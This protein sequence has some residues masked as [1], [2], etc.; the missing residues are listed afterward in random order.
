MSRGAVA[1]AAR[2]GLARK[3]VQTIVLALVV[4]VSTGASVL[5]LALVVDSSAPF[6]H[7]F[8]AQKG[9]DVSATADPSRVTAAQL[10]A[11]GR[12]PD[13][14][15]AAGPFGAVTIT[16]KLSSLACG[17]HAPAAGG[18]GGGAPRPPGSGPCGASLVFPPVTLVGRGSPGGSVDDVALQSGHWV[19]GPGQIVL[20]AGQNNFFTPSLG[21]KIIASDAPGKP[22]L[23]VVGYAS[24]ITDTAG[25]WVAP[26]E[27]S[28]LTSAQTPVS[29]QMLYRFRNAGTEQALRADMRAVAAALPAGA[30]SGTES[31]LAV[32][33]QETGNIAPFVPFL[34][35][36]GVIGMVMSVLIVVNVVSGAVVAGYRRIGILKSLGFTPGQ[37]VAAYTGQIAVPAVV[38]ALIGLVLGNV[39]AV[40]VLK[41]TASAYQIGSLRVPLWVDVAVPVAM[42]VLVAVA[43]MLSA[44]RAGRLS[45]VQA[46]AIG[47]APRTGR[48]YT[49]HRLLGRLNLPRPVTIG[50]AAPFSRPAR[51]V[52]TLSAVLLGAIAVTFAVGLSSS[53]D[54]VVSGLSHTTSEP[55][56]VAL[57]GGQGP[58]GGGAVISQINGG[59]APSPAKARS[60][61]VAALR[62]EPGTL[63]Y[64]A[65]GGVP[66]T[67][68]GLSQQV[69][70][71]AFRGN[72]RWTGYEMI[73]GHWYTGPG[74]VDVPTHFLNVT[75]TQVGDT[76]TIASD[77]HQERVRIVGQVF[78]TRS[79]GVGIFT[80]WQTARRVL[81]GLEPSFYQ[82]GVKPGTSIPQYASALQSR[83]GD[84]YAVFV[85]AGKSDTID[86]MLGLTAM[87][88][89]LLATVAGLGVLNTVVL[90]T[91]ERV[92]DLGV[93]KAIGMTPRQ[94]V[95]MVVCWVA[96]TGLL[97]GIIAVPA[98]VIL[99]S[100][101][102]PAMA[103]GADLIL[104]TSMI[105]VYGHGELVGLALA[106]MLIAV[107]GALLPA[108]WAA[109]IRTSSALHA[110]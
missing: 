17:P 64:V 58:D 105:N 32:R 75:G 85:N 97:A 88:T 70:I 42:C 22:K 5:A 95:A 57:P 73:S 47:R 28:R 7:A 24:S 67:V 81:P 40:P 12:L 38:G 49:A 27:I 78:A 68:T 43:A 15:A 61:L 98:G 19:T 36:F 76:I 69:P 50:L 37:V 100:Y 84:G 55:I 102:V 65:Q 41:Q 109:A 52:L 30:I 96:G 54:L 72:A 71:T 59:P 51:T 63:R 11:T 104:P 94:T 87:L 34:V 1:R 108:S 101:V 25:G 99:H 4:L 3:R 110:E 48:G 53:L 106:G 82:V 46:I 6:D 20:S 35:A 80:D 89:L 18:P 23:T 39:L 92:H 33:V 74:Q 16:P 83:L 13:V 45:A 10:T 14:T 93:F 8:G 2:G 79:G 56:Q 107:I 91:R 44:L 29:E 77:G 26:A 62:A 60:T 21:S 31:Y 103:A 90:H 86:L 66:V 9:A